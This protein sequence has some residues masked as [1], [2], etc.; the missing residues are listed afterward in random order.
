MV[1]VV[2]LAMVRTA[3]CA[4]VTVTMLESIGASGT[5]DGGVAFTAAM[6]TTDPASRSFWVVLRVAVQST[7]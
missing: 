4:A 6:L 1:A 2:D 5:P 7:N 3:V